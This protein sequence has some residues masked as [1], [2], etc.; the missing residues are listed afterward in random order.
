VA[1]TDSR[2]TERQLATFSFDATN[3][4]SHSDHSFEECCKGTA[5]ILGRATELL[6][7]REAEFR[8]VR[9]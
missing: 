1:S 7:V 3:V 9:S 4:V 8:A 5:A 2:T 6:A